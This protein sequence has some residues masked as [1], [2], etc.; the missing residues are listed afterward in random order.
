MK[1]QDAPWAFLDQYR[2]RLF[3]G[4]WPTIPQMLEITCERFGERRA[5]TAFEP[6][7]LAMSWKEVRAAARRTA[8]YLLAHGVRRGDRV[9]LTGKNCPEWAVAYLGILAA[10][11][12]VVPLDHQLGVQEMANLIRFVEAP[13]LFADEEKLESLAGA[14]ASLRLS[15]APG[16]PNYVLQLPDTQEPL[17]AQAETDTAAILFTSGTT[18]TPKGVTLSHRNLVADC[19]LSQANLRVLPTD[20]FYALMPIH[21]S[22][23]MTAVFL[24]C[25]SS[26]AEVLFGQKMVSKHILEDLKRGR[27]TMFLGVPMLFNRL[28]IGIRKGL[29]EKGLA[30]F[31][32]IR[33]LMLASGLIKKLFRVNPGKKMFGFLLK[34]VSLENIRICISGGGPLPASTF[35]QFNQLGIDFV[36]GYGLTETSPI[37]ALNPVEHYKETSVGKVIPQVQMRIREPDAEGRGEILIRGPVVMQGYYRNDAA[38]REVLSGDGWLSTGDVGYL[39]HENYLFLTGRKKSMIVTEGGKNV[40]PEEIEDRFQLHGEIEQIL[41]RGFLLDRKMMTEGIEAVVFPSAEQLKE[42]GTDPQDKEAVRLRIQ[43]VIDEVNS[44]LLPYQKI[45][46]LSIVDQAM[47]M[48]TTKKIKRFKVST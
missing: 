35:R 2:G 48:T 42:S 6:V 1:K 26:G 29:R 44:R 22:Y 3:Q 9:A 32:L 27:V 24:I 20:V 19:Y 17:G 33:G 12:V 4:E 15:L 47:E 31:A 21:H 8:A 37:V 39:D 18:G 16:R 7:T 14:G 43:A 11:A 23:T 36:Q 34:K 28:L 38:T 30:V 5:L 25:V 13:A 41:V 40:Y 46:R 10:G 45:Q